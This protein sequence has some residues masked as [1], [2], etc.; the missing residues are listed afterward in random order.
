MCAGSV[1]VAEVISNDYVLL[2]QTFLLVSVASRSARDE[3]TLVLY[4]AHEHLVF[5]ICL[6]LVVL[7]RSIP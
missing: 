6:L 3:W 5:G 2:F 1:G 7:V 4:T